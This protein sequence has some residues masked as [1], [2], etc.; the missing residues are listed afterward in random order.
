MTSRISTL[1]STQK[2]V[3]NTFKSK[4]GQDENYHP[5]ADF[6]GKSNPMG[7]IILLCT[8]SPLLSIFFDDL[9]DSYMARPSW[10]YVTQTPIT[11][12]SN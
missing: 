6:L 3:A 11:Y 4:M 1:R 7:S 5:K 10:V 9:C 8:V 12:N 2:Y